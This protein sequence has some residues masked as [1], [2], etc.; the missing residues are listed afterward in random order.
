MKLRTTLAMLGVTAAAST[1][2][3]PVAQAAPN[4][5]LGSAALAGALQG[6]VFCSGTQA[7]Y[8]EDMADARENAN[9]GHVQSAQNLHLAAERVRFE[10]HQAGCAWAA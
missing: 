4:N 8:N 7:E 6:A 9:G 5:G 2:A 1:A 3:V 10:A